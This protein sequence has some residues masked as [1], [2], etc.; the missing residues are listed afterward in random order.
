MA[1]KVLITVHP[2]HEFLV[3]I[4]FEYDINR[5]IDYIIQVVHTH[6]GK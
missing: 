3:R 1:V 2:G 4:Q 5:N 6:P